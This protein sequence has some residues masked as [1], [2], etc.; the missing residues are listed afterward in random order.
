MDGKELRE[1]ANTI[2]LSEKDPAMRISRKM[3][4]MIFCMADLVEDNC[5]TKNDVEILKA[6]KEKFK[7]RAVGAGAIL[8]TI[9]ALIVWILDRVFK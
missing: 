3:D 9:G 4:I 2:D 5:N 8:T 7:N 6:D 1:Q